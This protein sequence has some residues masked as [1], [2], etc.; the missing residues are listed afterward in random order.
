MCV[1]RRGGVCV[2]GEKMCVYEAWL[3]RRRVLNVLLTNIHLSI[4]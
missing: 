1:Y 3:V 2:H 4:T